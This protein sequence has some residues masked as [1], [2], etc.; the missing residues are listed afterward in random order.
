VCLKKLSIWGSSK[1]DGLAS[2]LR[3]RDYRIA[4]ELMGLEISPTRMGQAHVQI[5]YDDEYVASLTAHNGE[6][7]P[8]V[9]TKMSKSSKCAVISVVSGRGGRL[10]AVQYLDSSLLRIIFAFAA[11]PESRSV[12]A[13]QY[14]SR[15]DTFEL[16]I[17]M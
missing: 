2:C 10:Q 17:L 8:V 9:K 11:T 5:C 1:V 4:R 15:D 3:D 14:P 7:L 12:Q 13:A 16:F 6:V